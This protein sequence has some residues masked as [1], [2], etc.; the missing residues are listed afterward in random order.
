MNGTLADLL[1]GAENVRFGDDLPNCFE[2]NLTKENAFNSHPIPY[3]RVFNQ[4]EQ[5]VHQRALR[6][7]TLTTF[8]AML[9][10]RLLA[11]DVPTDLIQQTTLLQTIISS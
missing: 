2:T 9:G 7:D 1:F 11:G 4:N 10:N 5:H 6:K 8:S 3:R